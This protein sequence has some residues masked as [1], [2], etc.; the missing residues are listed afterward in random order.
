MINW[1]ESHLAESRAKLAI[2]NKVTEMLQMQVGNP[3]GSPISPIIRL[4]Q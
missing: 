4:L 3:E 2:Y 1:V